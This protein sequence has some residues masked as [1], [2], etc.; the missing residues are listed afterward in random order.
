MT[1]P[2]VG[3]AGTAVS[4]EPRQR[5][6]RPLAWRGALIVLLTASC[7]ATILA[8]WSSPIRVVLALSFFLFGPGLALAELLESRDLAQRLAIA[9]AASLGVET[10][11]AILLLYMG[12]FSIGV[13]VAVLDGLTIAFLGVAALRAL[14]ASGVESVGDA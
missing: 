10:L 4:H 3:D 9:P 13:A 1:A 6:L 11:V 12:A 14:R 7:T 8:G 5:A 2:P